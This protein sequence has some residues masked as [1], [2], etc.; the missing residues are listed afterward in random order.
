MVVVGKLI[1]WVKLILEL[2][3]FRIA[4]LVALS[5]AT[6]YVLGS[7]ELSA[8]ILIPTAGVLLLALGSGALNQFQ[9]RHHDGLM[10]RTSRRPIPSGRITSLKALLTSFLLM[11]SGT[12]ILWSGTNTT[13]TVLGILT[14]FWYNGIYTYL[15]RYSPLAVIP[16]SLIGALPP[17]IGW[18][19]ATGN[20][21]SVQPLILALFFFIWQIPHFWLLLLNFGQDYEK[22]GYPSLTTIL[23][24]HQLGRLTFMWILAT[25]ASI[26]LMP[27][28]GLGQS[29]IIIILLFMVSGLLIWNS[30][31]LL[32]RN[33]SSTTYLLAFKGINFFILGVMFLLAI[34]RLFMVH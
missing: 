14:V 2:G 30:S 18:S 34:D 11:L 4:L 13:A 22:A 21:W 27:L 15:K 29:E 9:E 8:R 5:T 33:Q 28:F 23:N 31:G 16:G 20:I 25:A 3:K 1:N 12:A 19:T 17:L 26:I 7:G 10:P 6:G 24:K 32:K